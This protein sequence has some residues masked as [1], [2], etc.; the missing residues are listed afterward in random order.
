[1]RWYALGMRVA[2]PTAAPGCLNALGCRGD[3]FANPEH[4]PRCMPWAYPVAAAA[5]PWECLVDALG[6]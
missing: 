6:R 3:A 4:P 1:M 2:T 5:K